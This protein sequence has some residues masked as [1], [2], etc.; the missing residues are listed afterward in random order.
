MQWQI[1]QKNRHALKKYSHEFHFFYD[2]TS[3]FQTLKRKLTPG[4]CGF[5]RNL[6]C[7]ALNNIEHIYQWCSECE[8]TIPLCS[9]K[10]IRVSICVPKYLWHF[11]T[12]NWSANF[13]SAANSNYIL[14]HLGFFFHCNYAHCDLVLWE[15]KYNS[16]LLD[17]V[18][19]AMGPFLWK[20]M[21]KEVRDCVFYQRCGDG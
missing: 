11:L 2:W 5:F 8:L 1:I 19:K 14:Y 6:N 4:E 7:T 10:P 3:T 12:L 13:Y 20:K 9:L 21:G 15:T 18:G 16:G 17:F